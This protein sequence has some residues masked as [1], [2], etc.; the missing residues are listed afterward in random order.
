[1][2]AMI[3]KSAADLCSS[4][5]AIINRL[6]VLQETSPG[7]TISAA[8]EADTELSARIIG[9]FLRHNPEFS[10]LVIDEM[11][12]AR[13]ARDGFFTLCLSTAH[14]SKEDGELLV[15]G[16]GTEFAV[17]EDGAGHIVPIRLIDE[18][19]GI[20]EIDNLVE[21]GFS[22]QFCDLCRKFRQ[23]EFDFLR[24]DRDGTIYPDLPQYEW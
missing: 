4:L 21:Y 15:K 12:S 9:T 5:E 20:D 11:T 19:N 24:L 13:P 16:G 8:V 23:E 17:Y 6:K 22:Q 2:T 3:N 7:D 10:R 18:A 14:V 1:M